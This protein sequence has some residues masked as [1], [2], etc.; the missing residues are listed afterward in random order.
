MKTVLKSGVL[1][2]VAGLRTMT[3]IA[4]VAWAANQRKVDLQDTHF[5]WLGGAVSQYIS[6]AMAAGELVADKLPMTPS[7]RLPG[8]FTARIV[9]GGLCGAAM[10]ASKQQATTGAILGMTGAVAGTLAGWNARRILAETLG[11]DVAAALLE[12]AVTISLAA[13]AVGACCGCE[14]RDVK[15]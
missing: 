11:C 8:P 1:G 12:D 3:P 13:W 5:A 2:F 6:A 7:R 10:G 9:S 4:A 14:S 15:E